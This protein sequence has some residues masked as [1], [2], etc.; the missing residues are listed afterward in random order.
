MKFKKY[1]T[2]NISPAVNH[3]DG[4]AYVIFRNG[5]SGV[6][7]PLTRKYRGRQN[8]Y[9]IYLDR[10]SGVTTTTAISRKSAYIDV[11][12]TRRI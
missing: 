4:G 11:R 8:S 12:R 5:R 6:A 9:Y 1:S 3:Y 7:S 10:G 2:E